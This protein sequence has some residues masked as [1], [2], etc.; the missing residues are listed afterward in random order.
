MRPGTPLV[1]QR[2]GG[3]TVPLGKDHQPDEVVRA[4]HLLLLQVRHVHVCTFRIDHFYVVGHLS[5]AR[6]E[7]V[8]ND[9]VVYLQEGCFDCQLLAHSLQIFH[10]G[11]YH[12]EG[13]RNDAIMLGAAATLHCEGFSRAGLAVSKYTYIVSI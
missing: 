11:E 4:L 6:V 1:V 3:L 9:F 10:V 8:V 7:E 12:V 5:L 2:G 13:A